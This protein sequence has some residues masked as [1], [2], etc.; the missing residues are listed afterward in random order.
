MLYFEKALQRENR[1][2][3]DRIEDVGMGGADNEKAA[4][5]VRAIVKKLR[6]R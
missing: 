3:A 5:E 2:R 4:R 1:A 6:G